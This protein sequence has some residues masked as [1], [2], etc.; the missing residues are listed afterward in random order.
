MNKLNIRPYIAYS[1]VIGSRAY[2]LHRPDSDT[3]RRGFYVLPAAWHW[4][5]ATPKRLREQI[6]LHQREGDDAVYWEIGKFVAMLLS[7]NPNMLETLFTPLV[8]VCSDIAKPLVENRERFLSKRII[9]TY[10]GYARQQFEKLR[11]NPEACAELGLQPKNYTNPGCK[12]GTRDI[13]LS[14]R[15]AMHMVRMM[16]GGISAL[17]DG[18]IMVDVTDSRVG[19]LAIRA[20]TMSLK[21]AYTMYLELEQEFAALKATTKLPEHPD[22]AWAA[23]YVLSVR[24]AMARTIIGVEDAEIYLGSEFFRGTADGMD[25][26]RHGRQDFSTWLETVYDPMAGVLDAEPLEF[27]MD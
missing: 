26:L 7:N 1:S 2:G 27:T 14:R 4:S 18:T 12:A 19:L 21:D 9:N 23:R 11:A 20:G 24:A 15:N 8:E 17:R 6:E 13:A 5:P 10:G 3:D 22:T 25:L 16:L